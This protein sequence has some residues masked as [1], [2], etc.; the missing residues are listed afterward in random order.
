MNRRRWAAVVGVLAAF[1]ALGLAAA[2]GV[3]TGTSVSTCNNPVLNKSLAEWGAIR[4]PAPARPAITDHSAARF[5]FAQRSIT[6]L[7]PSFYLPQQ[8]VRAGERWTFGYD[9]QTTQAG[10]ARVE[11]DWYSTPEGD[12]SGYLGHVNG[13]WTTLPGGAGWVRIAEEFTAPA[14]AT[15]GN[16]LSDVEFT[17]TG[18]TLL[19]TACDYRAGAGATPTSGPTPT[20]SPPAQ[21][22]T[23]AS[24]HGW[25]AAL[26]GSDEFDVSGPV[27]SQRWQ[28]P[29]GEE[30]GTPGCQAGPGGNGR[31]CAKNASVSGG[32]L[33]LTGEENGDTG[34]VRNRTDRR[35]G[36][37]EVRSRSRDAG[38]SGAPYR[39][40]H[41]VVPSS[42]NA[43]ADGEY[44]WIEY[45]NPETACLGALLR[46]PNS[47]TGDAVYRERC[48]VDVTEWHHYAFE[49]TATGLVGYL[50]GV[51]WFRVDGGAGPGNRLDVQAM[52][53][54]ALTAQLDNLTGEDGLR[55]AVLE[56][57]WIRLYA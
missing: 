55:P 41:A 43:A 17:A 34:W 51:E 18:A 3:T 39:V 26:A 19:A 42:G 27:D 7:N 28:V 25:G 31:R 36:R 5:A 2:N 50:D 16:V 38:E 47:S 20:T 56:I 48:P 22:T 49:W 37:W 29:A 12:N 53:S 1:P 10:R 15:R 32:V 14:G 33:A 13:G 45:A 52:P 9:A 40:R 30:G 23:A 44:G 46:Y 8:P 54:G 57:D 24:R 21:P 11:V 4:G 6:V 35:Y